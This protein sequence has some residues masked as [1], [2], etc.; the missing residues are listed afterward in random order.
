MAY[1]LTIESL[2]LD[3]YAAFAT[4]KKNKS[5]KEYVKVFEGR[6]RSNLESL[7]GDLMNKTYK[8]EPSSCFIVNRPKKR[9]VFAAQFRD[10]VVHH[11]Y[12]NYTHKLFER[13]FIYDTYSCIPNRGTH[14]GIQRLE[15]HIRKETRNYQNEAYILKLDMRGY[16]MHINRYKLSEIAVDSLESMRYHKISKHG[17][18]VFDDIMDFE[19][20]EWLTREIVMLNPKEN[21]KIV[22][23]EDEWIGLDKSKSLFH[24]PDGCGMPIGNLTSQLFS[25]V[26]LNKFDQYMKRELKCKH[27]GRY[28]D[29]AYIVSSDKKWLMS[30]IPDIKGF[31]SQELDL[32]LHMGKLHMNNSKYGVDFLGAYVRPFRRYVSNNTLRRTEV[33]M[34]HIP[35]DDKDAAFR[36][37]NSF[38]GV[39]VHHKT[40]NIRKRLFLKDKFLSIGTFDKDITKFTL[41]N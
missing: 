8:P 24:T 29:D 10:R 7:A 5:S 13:T 15:S 34:R 36:S 18:E 11:L 38:L 16:F 40:Y 2:M 26:Y 20:L 41:N 14:F 21:C 22:G 28:V 12:Y 17:K 6:L 37:I 3:L 25:N 19:F 35:K 33:N 23:R 4:A 1:K 9:E 39:L 31:L 32:E 27:Y 30:I